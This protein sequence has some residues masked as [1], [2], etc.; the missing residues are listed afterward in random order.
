MIKVIPVPVSV[1][2]AYATYALDTGEEVYL[3]NLSIGED[4]R[5]FIHS[6][7]AANG[8]M[9]LNTIYITSEIHKTV[10]KRCAED[11]NKVDT[12]M[13]ARSVS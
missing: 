6:V 9:K 13:E 7:T 8:K 12:H 2:Q 1:Y 5:A 3:N 11:L 10:F 4:G